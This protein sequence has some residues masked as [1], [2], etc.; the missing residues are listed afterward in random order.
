MYYMFRQN[1]FKGF[2]TILIFLLVRIPLNISQPQDNTFGEKTNGGRINKINSG[3]IGI[4]QGN[5]GVH[6]GY[7]GIQQG[8]IG[9]HWGYI[10]VHWGYIGVQG[11]Y[12]QVQR[13]YI[14][15]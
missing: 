1:I 6:C 8:Q 9:V 12:I 11:G 13:G 10:V 3:Y 14:I 5:I 15:K 4:Q 7:I 2:V